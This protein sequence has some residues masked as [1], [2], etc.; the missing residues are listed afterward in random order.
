[1]ADQYFHEAHYRPAQ[2]ITVATGLPTPPGSSRASIPPT[3]SES[4]IAGRKRSRGDIFAPED[5]SAENA[6]ATLQSSSPYR[7]EPVYGPG[8]TLIYPNDPLSHYAPEA[9]T[10]SGTWLEE[11]QEQAAA[12]E[13]LRP[14]MPTRKSQRL[15]P[16]VTAS[17]TGD[18]LARKSPSPT[19]APGSDTAIDEASRLLGISWSRMDATENTKIAQG[20]YTRWIDKHYPQLSNVE[21]W[22]E[23]SA[24]PAYLG[25]ATN[26]A[27]GFEEYYLWSHNLAEGILVTRNPSDLV[28]KL[29]SPHM[30]LSQATDKIHADIEPVVE[31]SAANAAIVHNDRFLDHSTADASQAGAMDLD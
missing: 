27:N 24:I 6:N 25:K 2:G 28:V 16:A 11:K 31:A 14:I 22:F 15:D 19:R 18:P 5:E 13:V 20:A 26:L 4:S 21:V 12:A 10:Q 30:A 17:I 9:G 7:G 1:M 29:S 8:M 23:N 3:P